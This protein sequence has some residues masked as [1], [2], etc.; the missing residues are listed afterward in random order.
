M[1]SLMHDLQEGLLDAAFVRLPCESSKAFNLRLI[2]VEPMMAALHRSHPLSERDEV[3]LSELVGTPLVLFPHE[4]APG[5]YELVFNACLRAGLAPADSQQASQLS[6]SLSMV[7]AGFGFALVPVSMQCIGHPEVTFHR[8][9]DQML[10][11]DIALA[12]RKFE[13]SPSVRRLVEM[14]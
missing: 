13:R 9:S 2:D 5:L 4:V 6:S 11:T 8:L 12:W 1:A 3:A 7:A 10:K 14:F